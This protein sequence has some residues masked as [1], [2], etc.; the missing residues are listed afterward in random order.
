LVVAGN[1][2][3]FA[4]QNTDFLR[5]GLE[6]FYREQPQINIFSKHLE[7]GIFTFG[8]FHGLGYLTAETN[9]T[10]TPT[11]ASFTRLPY[12]FQTLAAAQYVAASYEVAVGAIPALM[13]DGSWGL[14]ATET[15]AM[16]EPV[17]SSTNRVALSTNGQIV[18]I[19]DS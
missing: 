4:A 5:I 17:P 11:N 3:L 10:T 18:L 1:R 9:F 16:S 19:S 13:A 15:T 8:H 14:Y 2:S 6:Q 7:I 12:A